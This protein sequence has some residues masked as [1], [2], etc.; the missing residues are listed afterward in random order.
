MWPSLALCGVTEQVHDDGALIDGLVDVE[1]VLAGDPAVLLGL[2]PA[3]TALPHADDDI[4]A[5]VAEVETLSVSLRTVADEGEGVVLE[6]FLVSLLVF[7][8]Q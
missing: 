6:V 1:E 3:G 8:S 5:V 4:E 7:R 2:L